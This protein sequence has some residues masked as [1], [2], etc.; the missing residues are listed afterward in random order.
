MADTDMTTVPNAPAL[1]ECTDTNSII[2][3]EQGR[4][5]TF[6]HTGFEADG[7]ATTEIVY[8]STSGSAPTAS[9][10]AATQKG[11]L[12]SGNGPIVVGPGLERVDLKCAANSAVVQVLPSE[13]YIGRF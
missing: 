3:L 11:A 5:Y 4:A 7:D 8:L 9:M 12:I 1:V 2:T 13:A 6:V 10:A